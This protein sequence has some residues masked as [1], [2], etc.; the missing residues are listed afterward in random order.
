MKYEK[1]TVRQYILQQ[2]EIELPK[3]QKKL[4]LTYAE[5]KP[6]VG[7]LIEEG[8]LEFVSG[9]SYKIKPKEDTEDAQNRKTAPDNVLSEESEMVNNI[10]T[11]CD[12]DDFDS[13]MQRLLDEVSENEDEKEN[14][15]P[16]DIRSLIVKCLECGLQDNNSGQKY[17]LGLNG[18]LQFELK[19]VQEGDALRISDCGKTF[20]VAEQTARKVKNVLKNYESVVL[21]D[22]GEMSITIENPNGT[23]MALLTLYAATD[24]V[25]KMK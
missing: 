10:L 19:L 11:T 21:E 2:T 15:L 4:E 12:T 7:E 25:K 18:E 14:E 3:I 13:Y 5:L 17:I 6:I 22:N 8:L 24:A 9:V 16:N 20:A 23:L 1:Q